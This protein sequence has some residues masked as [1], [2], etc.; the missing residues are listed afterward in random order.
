MF[1]TASMPTWMDADR[2]KGTAQQAEGTVKRRLRLASLTS[3]AECTRRLRHS[4]CT[5]TVRQTKTAVRNLVALRRQERS[6]RRMLYRTPT[7]N[8]R[9]AS[10]PRRASRVGRAVARAS[11]THRRAMLRG[12]VSS[13]IKTACGC[14]FPLRSALRVIS[15]SHFMQEKICTS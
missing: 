4:A 11:L 2:I 6:R 9:R 13:S 3:L 14:G 8:G 7:M 1:N 12:S 10:A 15:A 5:R